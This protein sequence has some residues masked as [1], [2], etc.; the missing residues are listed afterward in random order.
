MMAFSNWVKS[1]NLLVSLALAIISPG[2]KAKIT[3]VDKT[4]MIAMTMRSSRRVKDL[5]ILS[6]IA[7]KPCWFRCKIKPYL[8]IASVSCFT[9]F[10]KILKTFRFITLKGLKIAFINSGAYLKLRIL[11]AKKTKG[12]E[13]GILNKKL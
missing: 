7:Q 11:S 2:S 8:E 9:S 12:R 13:K 1:V 6:I 3:T 4:A 10:F 5:F